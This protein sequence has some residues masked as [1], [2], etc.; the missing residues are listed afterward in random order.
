[1]TSCRCL[2][3][4]DYGDRLDAMDTRLAG[5]AREPGWGVVQVPAEDG[6]P[7]WAFTVG[8]WHSYRAAELAM[9]G[10]ACDLM[11]ELLNQ[12]A[13]RVKD[14]RPPLVDTALDDVLEGSARL[15]VRLADDSWRAALFG[16]SAGFYRATRDVPTHQVVWSDEAGRFP[17]QDGHPDDFAD[18]QPSLWLPVDR[19]PPGPWRAEADESKPSLNAHDNLGKA[20][21]N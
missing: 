17:W 3:C 21:L 6:S 10:L 19:H 16:I 14:G 13:Q 12:L 15:T 9:F 4:Q 18:A 20:Y 2:V 1:V 7:G 11:H 5:W 8:L